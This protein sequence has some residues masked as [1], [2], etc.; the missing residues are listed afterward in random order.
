M[1]SS[2]PHRSSAQKINFADT[3]A[4]GISRRRRG[5]SW[6]FLDPDGRTI[7][8][9]KER[10]RLL[11]LALPPAYSDAWYNPDP[12]GHILAMGRDAR[13]RRQYRYHPDWRS[14]REREKFADLSSFGQALPQ[15][16]DAAARSLRKGAPSQDRVIAAIVRLLDLGYLRVGNEA[17][18][19]DNK[20]FGATTLRRR[21]AKVSGDTIQ[22]SF[23]GKS[24]KDRRVKLS[25]RSLATTIR[26]CQELSGQHL[27]CFETADG[28]VKPVRSDDVNAWLSDVAGEPITARQ[29]RT[30][31][32]SVIA[33]ECV[34]D[35]T[36]TLDAAMACVADKL[37][38]TPKIARNSYVHPAVIDRIK[39]P[40]QS[41]PPPRGPRNLAPIERRLMG[42]M[43]EFPYE[44][45]EQE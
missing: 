22:L 16:R 13:G 6:Q 30:W 31:W 7:T 43:H 5:R 27:F 41:M 38:N 42:L 25:D 44:T 8:C 14:E 15:V 10:K 20:S 26:R 24:G 12:Y 35:S 32:A 39:N 1:S 34:E 11:S 9:A 29:F 19:R 37:G 23:R 17:Y 2:Q 40:Q 21:H 18:A 36:P 4:P 28:E 3:T 45:M 33:L